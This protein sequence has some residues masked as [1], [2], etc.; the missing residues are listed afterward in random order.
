MIDGDDCGTISGLYECQ[1][2]QKKKQKQSKIR[3][4]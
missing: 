4:F 3:G 2:K 1:G